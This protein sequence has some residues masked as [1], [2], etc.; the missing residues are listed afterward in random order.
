MREKPVKCGG[1]NSTEASSEHRD[2]DDA[3]KGLRGRSAQANGEKCMASCSS[4]DN[5]NELLMDFSWSDTGVL[6][7]MESDA[8]RQKLMMLLVSPKFAILMASAIFI[9]T[10][11]MG[12]ELYAQQ[13]AK[14]SEKIF[15]DIRFPEM[16]P[17]LF[18]AGEV[19]FMMLFLIE[20]GARFYVFRWTL[21]RE[22]F[23]YVDLL[24][25]LPSLLLILSQA[26]DCLKVSLIDNFMLHIASLLRISF[27]KLGFYHKLAPGMHL[28]EAA[29]CARASVFLLRQVSQSTAKQRSL[30]TIADRQL[31][32]RVSPL[33]QTMAV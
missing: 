23:T 14:S 20:F 4:I 19:V 12:I 21:F 10:V 18:V 8:L 9:N 5:R 3:E 27:I 30:K 13:I 28:R 33:I 6:M 2:K 24:S 26:E 7:D 11:A 16:P 15:S 31:S 22:F 25:L 17:S 29:L 32:N 1:A